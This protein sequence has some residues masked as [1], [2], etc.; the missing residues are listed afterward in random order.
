MKLRCFTYYMRKNKLTTYSPPPLSISLSV[1]L[2]SDDSNL[3]VYLIVNLIDVI[4]RMEIVEESFF[5]FS[6]RNAMNEN[7]QLNVLNIHCVDYVQWTPA[8]KGHKQIQLQSIDC[9]SLDTKLVLI[10]W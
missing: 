4:I 1:A 8:A 3:T 6:M 10:D 2:G 7:L 9:D 5:S